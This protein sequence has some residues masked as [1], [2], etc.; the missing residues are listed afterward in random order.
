[1]ALHSG[2]ADVRMGD[3]Y[4]TAVNRCAR[5]R[6]LGHGGQTLLAQATADLVQDHMPEGVGLTDL[7]EHRLKDLERPEHL[8]QLLY[9]GVLAVFPPLNSLNRR[10][11][12]LPLQPTPF[13]GRAA[14]LADI[15]Q[16]LNSAGVRLLTTTGPG[17]IG[18][19]RLA[20]QVLAMLQDEFRHGVYF[21]PLQPFRSYRCCKIS[22]CC[23][24]HQ[25]AVTTS[26]SCYANMRPKPWPLQRMT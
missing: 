9:P 12:N 24:G 23:A 11:S 18:K 13:V 14:E 22:H 21:V 6:A 4:G 1:M 10:P 3:Y 16:R 17:G 25:T 15:W 7:G 8:F 5:I 20:L 2:Q 26:M 19:T